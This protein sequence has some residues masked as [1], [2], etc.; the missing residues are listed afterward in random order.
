MLSLETGKDF[1]LK[2]EYLAPTED[3]RKL[4]MLEKFSEQRL[5]DRDFEKHVTASLTEFEGVRKRLVIA[6]AEAAAGWHEK[7]EEKQEKIKGGT[8]FDTDVTA[9]WLGVILDKSRSM[10]PYLDKLRAEILK[11]FNDAYF[12]EVNGCDLSRPPLAPWFYCAPADGINP[13]T[14]DRFIPEV[15]K[16]SDYPY[17]EFISWTRDASGALQCMA[18]LMEKDAIYWFCDFDDPTDDAVIKELA[19]SFMEKKIR[20]YV[21]TLGKRPPELIVKLAELSGGKVIRKR[22]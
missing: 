8:I 18:E 2:Y 19:R 22:V 1:E 5:S 3:R 21:H 14:S 11:D 9:G 20:L 13:F 10:A 16:F 17:S 6:E 4:R 15:P 7:D 12:V